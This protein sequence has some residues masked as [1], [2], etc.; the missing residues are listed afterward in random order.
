VDLEKERRNE[1]LMMDYSIRQATME[2]LPSLEALI[3]L[4][5]RGLSTK[6]YSSVQIEAAL[7]GAFGVGVLPHEESFSETHHERIR[8]VRFWFKLHSNTSS[9]Q[10][11]HSLLRATLEGGL[12]YLV[13]HNKS[14]SCTH[15]FV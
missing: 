12:F 5:V 2:D 6:D 9:Y 13:N 1:G 15:V 14:S 4:F 7:C 10:W 11:C 8:G 3:A